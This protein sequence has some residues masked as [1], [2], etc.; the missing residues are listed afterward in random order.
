MTGKLQLKFF[1]FIFFISIFNFTVQAK[2][3]EV[4]N[5]SIEEILLVE[6]EHYNKLPKGTALEPI[7]KKVLSSDDKIIVCQ[8]FSYACP[9]CYLFEPYLIRWARKN[10]DKFD[11]R[12]VH[13]FF[14]PSWELLGKSYYAAV[15]MGQL[16]AVH[17]ALFYHL[18]MEHEKIKTEEALFKVISKVVDIEEFKK[19]FYSSKV[20]S[21][22][23]DGVELSKFLQISFIP[24]TLV[25][26]K[27]DIFLISPTLPKGITSIEVIEHLA[28]KYS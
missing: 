17:I 14:S 5:K 10:S 25:K 3:D 15:E 21:D 7:V 24:D 27:D 12:H 6:G 4:S 13:I 9:G 18:H 20:E 26:I 2:E 1:I 19:H 28:S 16:E 22:F 8:F 11:L 23:K